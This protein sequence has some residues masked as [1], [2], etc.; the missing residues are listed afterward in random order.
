MTA[1]VPVYDAVRVNIA[2]LP[3]GYAAGYSTGTGTVPW[4]AADWAAHPGAVRID[5]DPAASDP[6]ADILDVEAGAATFA[7]C[8]G[9]YKRALADYRSAARPGQRAP[10]IY[11]SL[12]NLPAVANALI[13]GGV[14][15]GPA[16]WVAAWS[17][18]EPAAAWLVAGGGGPFPVIGVQYRNAGAYDVSVFSA[19]WLAAVSGAPPPAPAHPGW[20]YPAPAAVG[21]VPSR[22]VWLSWPAAV[23]PAGHPAPGSYTAAVYAGGKLVRQVTVAG[24]GVTVA[25]LGAGSYEA[26]VWANGAPAGPPHASVRFTA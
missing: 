13:S 2:Q 25:G 1:T 16:L 7:D 9:W 20:A 19:A 8:P 18:L 12:S 24:L 14:T 23:P 6:T 22:A 26:R 15:S 11:A 5:Q 17:L 3:P 4:T 21:A 10:A